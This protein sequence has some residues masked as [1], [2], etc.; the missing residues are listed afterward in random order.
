[1]E[2]NIF[3]RIV[4]EI[5]DDLGIYVKDFLNVISFYSIIER[6]FAENIIHINER[7]NFKAPLLIS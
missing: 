3:L 5:S 6:L 7:K 2:K 1:M 4:I